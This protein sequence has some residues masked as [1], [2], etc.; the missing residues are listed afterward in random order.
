MPHFDSTF[1]MKSYISLSEMKILEWY[2]G[3]YMD[4]SQDAWSWYK[5]FSVW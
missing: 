3:L 1:A 4:F 2:Y 5:L